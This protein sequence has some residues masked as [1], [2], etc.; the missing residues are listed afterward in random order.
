M[1]NPEH[2]FSSYG[3]YMYDCMDLHLCVRSVNTWWPSPVRLSLGSF[4]SSIQQRLLH[5][6]GEITYRLALAEG[7]N[8]LP[9]HRSYPVSQ[10]SGPKRKWGHSHTRWDYEGD[11]LIS[12][13]HVSEIKV[14]RFGLTKL[15]FS[16]WIMTVNI[17]WCASRAVRKWVQGHKVA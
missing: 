10:K 1:E 11:K 6:S 16:T 14:L 13:Q 5:V 15:S 12:S 9:Q 17:W 2:V 4:S 7:R 3:D 8:H